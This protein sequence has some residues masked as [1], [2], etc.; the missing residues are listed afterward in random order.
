MLGTDKGHFWSRKQQTPNFEN[1]SREI[2]GLF[3]L[4]NL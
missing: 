3:Q 2:T 4:D 1:V